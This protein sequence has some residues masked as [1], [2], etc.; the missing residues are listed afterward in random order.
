MHGRPGPR[1]SL[2]RR[3]P[4]S[5]YI[6]PRTDQFPSGNGHTQR[7]NCEIRSA[8]AKDNPAKYHGKYQRSYCSRHQS[9]CQPTKVLVRSKILSLLHQNVQC[10][11]QR[12]STFQSVQWYRCTFLHQRTGCFQAN[13]IPSDRL[14]CP[15]LKQ[16]KSSSRVMPIGKCKLEK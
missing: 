1:D 2:V 15:K 16:T 6:V 3:S 9:K 5:S 10:T 8:Q 14:E 12:H 13:C 4:A 11:L 7:A